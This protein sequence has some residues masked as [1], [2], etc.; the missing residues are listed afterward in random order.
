[1]AHFY[2]LR[3]CPPHSGLH[4]A[5][6]AFVK[7]HPSPSSTRR[8][9]P[10]S[11]LLSALPPAVALFWV[12]TFWSQAWAAILRGGPWRTHSAGAGAVCVVIFVGCCVIC[13]RGEVLCV[14]GALCASTAVCCIGGWLSANV[15]DVVCCMLCMLT[16]GGWVSVECCVL[17]CCA[18]CIVCAG[19]RRDCRGCG[20]LLVIRYPPFMPVR[21]PMGMGQI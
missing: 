4:L 3:C 14:S 21:L 11:R 13:F 18:L 10:V 17:A 2:Q 8:K 16:V 15:V 12:R 7:V 20:H 1:M 6:G 5:V 9:P 19:C